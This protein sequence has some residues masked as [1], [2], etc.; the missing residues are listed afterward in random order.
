L[1][2]VKSRTDEKY[3]WVAAGQAVARVLLYAEI[4]GLSW[5]FL[6]QTLLSKTAREELLTGIG[7]KGFPQIVLR[8]GSRMP[9]TTIQPAAS[10]SVTATSPG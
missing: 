3:G 5:S 9:L 10:R 7:R 8:F 2:V 6:N 1:A 4:S